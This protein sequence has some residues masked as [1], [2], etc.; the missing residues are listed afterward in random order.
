[1]FIKLEPALLGQIVCKFKEV[2]H[3]LDAGLDLQ[4]P[5]CL[6]AMNFY[7]QTVGIW[8]SE[9]MYIYIYTSYLRHLHPDLRFLNWSFIYISIPKYYGPYPFTRSSYSL[10]LEYLDNYLHACAQEGG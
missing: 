9:Q 10:I 5:R 8:Q 6:S 2:V 1:M 4:D 7:Y 3:H